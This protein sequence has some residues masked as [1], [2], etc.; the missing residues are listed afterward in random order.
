MDRPAAETRQLARMGLK[1]KMR[2]I[3]IAQAQ[4]A[5]NAQ[6]AKSATPYLIV[7]GGF[8]FLGNAHRLAESRPRLATAPYYAAIQTDALAYR[9]APKAPPSMG[10]IAA[11]WRS[12]AQ[13]ESKTEPRRTKT[14]GEAARLN[15]QSAICVLSPQTAQAIIASMENVLQPTD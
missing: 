11:E 7:W 6:M 12:H 9:H 1:I 2:S 5:R 4:Y 14:A 8:A 3:L 15:A 10:G 13:M